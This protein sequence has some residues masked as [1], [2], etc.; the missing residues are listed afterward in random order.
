MQAMSVVWI[1]ANGFTSIFMVRTAAGATGIMA[2]AQPCSRADVL[3]F[4]E[5]GVTV[6]TSPAPVAMPFQSGQDRAVLTFVTGVG[7]LANLIVPA[8][9]AAIFLADLETVDPSNAQVAALIA[10]AIGSLTDSNGNT[11]TAY[12]AGIRLRRPQAPGA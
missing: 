7:T 6:N 3:Q 12:Q 2:A 10:A 8:P 4:W 1:D 5:G 11:V 9:D